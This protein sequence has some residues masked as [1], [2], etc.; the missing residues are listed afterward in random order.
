LLIEISIN[1]LLF[2]N[3]NG[4]V[5]QTDAAAAPDVDDHGAADAGGASPAP[6]DN[7]TLRTPSNPSPF[8]QSPTA[9][10]AGSLQLSPLACSPAADEIEIATPAVSEVNRSLGDA[11]TLLGDANIAGWSLDMPG[12]PLARGSAWAGGRDHTP[13][14]VPQ[15]WG[16]T[17]CR[18][19]APLTY[20]LSDVQ[21]EP[22]EP[23][24]QQPGAHAEAQ[25]PVRSSWFGSWFG[26]ASSTRTSAFAARTE[27]VQAEE[28][29]AEQEKEVINVVSNFNSFGFY[30]DEEEEE[31]ATNV[32]R[33]SVCVS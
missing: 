23:P 32:V 10:A 6:Q 12:F 3:L 9:S 18:E 1:S 21:V 27:E 28:A 8:L 26:G 19:V 25:P 4:G 13:S 24:K 14:R 11:K 29:A 2:L 20:S 31:E 22:V 15:R 7:T 16:T 30:G 5:M 17:S 33:I